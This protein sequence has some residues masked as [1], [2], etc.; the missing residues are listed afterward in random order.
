[1]AAAAEHFV[2]VI[3]LNRAVGRYIAD[4]TGAEAG[5]VTGGAASGM[6]LSLAACMTGTNIAKVHQLPDTAGMRSNVV[7]QKIH[8]GHYSRL[9]G[10]T[11]AHLVEV[12]NLIETFAEELEAAIDAQTAAVAYLFGPGIPQTGLTLPE[13]VAIAHKRHVPVIVDAAA[14]L[15]PR[16][17]LRRYLA[18][19]AD[20]VTFSGGKFIKGP[21]ATG[22]LFGRKDLID[23]ALMNANPHHGVGRPQK[24]SKEEMVGL[25][26]ALRR[27]MELDE[28]AEMDRLE[29]L[30]API[31]EGLKDLRGIDM[32]IQKDA[33]FP[34]PVLVIGLNH[35]DEAIAAQIAQRLLHG[36]PRIF[37]LATRRR[38]ELVVNPTGLSS[39]DTP[40]VLRRLREELHA[41]LAEARG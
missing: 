22:L 9:Y 26:V 12:G 38:P 32:R 40:L 10:L 13:T 7:L 14:M 11:G 8:R 37:L 34:V 16:A 2:D 29:A 15:P 35:P 17:N 36:K 24:V 30:L 6:V 18:E 41:A 27:Y 28:G 21:Q 5:M 25:Y 20:L 1:M 23:A 19:G 3:E 31:S 33:E 4:I 39:G